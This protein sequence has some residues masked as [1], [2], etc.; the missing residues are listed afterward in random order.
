MLRLKKKQPSILYGCV[1]KQGCHSG[2]PNLI[3][4]CFIV[5]SLWFIME[6]ILHLCN[7]I[8]TNDTSGQ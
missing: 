3:T 7:Y 8:V 6:S 2:T 1:V 4:D 5:S